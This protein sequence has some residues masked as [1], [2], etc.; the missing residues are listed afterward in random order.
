MTTEISSYERKEII[1]VFAPVKGFLSI[2]FF[3]SP[4]SENLAFLQTEKMYR[5]INVEQQS[6]KYWKGI[7]LTNSSCT[8]NEYKFLQCPV[9][10]VKNIVIFFIDDDVGEKYLEFISLYFLFIFE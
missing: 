10:N 2:F 5:I 9:G 3:K 8:R 4:V 1:N 7:V 6:I